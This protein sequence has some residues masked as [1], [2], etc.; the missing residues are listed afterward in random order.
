[1]AFNAVKCS[2]VGTD[3]GRR[4]ELVDPLFNQTGF[5]S[6]GFS[7]EVRYSLLARR[8]GGRALAVGL[9]DEQQ[10]AVL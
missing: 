9:L 4:H 7:D 1:M 10:P 3:K 5:E 8:E 6:A 2:R